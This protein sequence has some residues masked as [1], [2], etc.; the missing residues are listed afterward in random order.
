MSAPNFR[1]WYRLPMDCLTCE[2]L[3]A[4]SERLRERYY[5]AR[6]YLDSIAGTSKLAAYTRARTEANN[7]WIEA[8]VARI[9]L[10]RHQRTHAP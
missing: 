4:E 7:A 9:E 2:Q 5:E 8:E 3:Q 1:Q 10:D 6:A